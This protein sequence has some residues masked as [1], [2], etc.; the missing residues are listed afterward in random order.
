V[1]LFDLVA[2]LTLLISALIGLS[3]GAV[4]EVVTL[5]AFTVAA[6]LSVYLLPF[7]KPLALRTVHPV[8]AA[9]AVAV[10]LS[11]LI[12][13]IGLRLAGSSLSKAIR[14][15]A[16]LGSLDRTLGLA[17]GVV[18]ALVV[19][20]VVYLVFAATPAHRPPELMTS[21]RLYPLARGSGVALASLAPGGI[22]KLQGFGTSLKNRMSGSEPEPPSGPVEAGQAYGAPPVGEPDG[23]APPPPPEDTIAAPRRTLQI[24]G[25]AP[26]PHRHHHRPAAAPEE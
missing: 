22:A 1:N 5:F 25:G 24:E 7:T 6:A 21:A 23:S 16:T 14:S 20:G 13:Y 2:G 19:L 26:S 18:R 15:Q 4:L 8:W 10:G 11:F 17:F 3:R 12:T 9:N